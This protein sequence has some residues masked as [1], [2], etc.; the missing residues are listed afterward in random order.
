MGEDSTKYGEFI[1]SYFAWLTLEKQKDIVNRLE[2]A[3]K[4]EWEVLSK[5][6]FLQIFLI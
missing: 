2:D 4:K 1:S 3:T 5:G 6:L